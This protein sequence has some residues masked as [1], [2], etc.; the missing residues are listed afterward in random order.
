MSYPY[1][2]ETKTTNLRWIQDF[3]SDKRRLQQL[4]VIREGFGSD[5]RLTEEWRDIEFFVDVKK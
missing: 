1:K 4:M 2:E 5:A 3:G